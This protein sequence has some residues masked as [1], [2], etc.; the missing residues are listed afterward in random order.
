MR[1]LSDKADSVTESV[2]R[3]VQEAADSMEREKAALAESS[4]KLLDENKAAIAAE[5]SSVDSSVADEK[6]KLENIIAE[7]EADAARAA[8]SIRAV[9]SESLET[10]EGARRGLDDARDAFISSASEFFRSEYEKLL[11]SVKESYDGIRIDAEAMLEK[12]AGTLLETR[13]TISILSEGETE[14]IADIVERLDPF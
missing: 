11:S 10:I 1:L 7:A 6:Q 5:L 12:V 4:T 14:K 2:A 3:S 9:S 8:E 13:E